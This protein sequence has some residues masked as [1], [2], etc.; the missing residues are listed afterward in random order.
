MVY[1]SYE[2]NNLK[3]SS[4]SIDIERYLGRD[5]YQSIKIKEG[6]KKIKKWA[7]SKNCL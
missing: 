2:P 7:K 4:T 3:A 6:S 1:D 5:S